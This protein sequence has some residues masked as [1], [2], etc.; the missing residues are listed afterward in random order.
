[1][2]GLVLEGCH[3]PAVP[4]HLSCLVLSKTR[5]SIVCVRP[6]NKYIGCVN[7]VLHNAGQKRRPG[8]TIEVSKNVL[9]VL[10]FVIRTRSLA[11]RAQ[12]G[13]FHNLSEP[14]LSLGRQLALSQH[15]RIPG[16]H[17]KIDPSICQFKLLEKP[18]EPKTVSRGR[19]V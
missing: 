6:C 3:I 19:V 17:T 2:F 4:P 15:A 8:L 5:T 7:V 18:K 16:D 11:Q 9:H 10:P 1:M 13:M 14:P 12:C